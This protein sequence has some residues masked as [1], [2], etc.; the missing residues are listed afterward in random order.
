MRGKYN[1]WYNT[2]HGTVQY[3]VQYGTVQYSTRQICTLFYCLIYCLFY[4][5]IYLLYYLFYFII[6]LLFYVVIYCLFCLH[7]IALPTS[8]PVQYGC[9]PENICYRKYVTALIL[10]REVVT[11]HSATRRWLV[12]G[13]TAP[14]RWLVTAHT[15]PRRW[16]V[17]LHPGGDWS[18]CNQ[19]TCHCLHFNQMVTACHWSHC[20]RTVR[21]WQ[22]FIRPKQYTRFIASY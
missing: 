7:S 22:L 17:T 14:R 8:C 6:Y 12:S 5:I 2:V 21:N 18:L 11:G 15:A 16:I 20:N 9:N 19:V 3:K 10:W 13:H 1:T 4:L